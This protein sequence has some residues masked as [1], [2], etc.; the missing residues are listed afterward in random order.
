MCE[1][2]HR[3]VGLTL[4]RIELARRP[5]P[6]V[7]TLRASDPLALDPRHEWT[8]PATRARIER[9]LVLRARH[10]GTIRIDD[11]RRSEYPADALARAETV[12]TRYTPELAELLDQGQL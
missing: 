3:S 9:P 2:L 6:L 11:E 1:E 10:V 12:I 5:T 4:F 8:R 7:I